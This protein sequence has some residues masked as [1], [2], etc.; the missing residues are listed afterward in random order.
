MVA[1]RPEPVILKNM[2]APTFSP[3]VLRLH[4]IEQSLIEADIRRY[5]QEALSTMSPVPSSDV[6]DQ[7]TRQSGKLFI[8]AATVARYINPEDKVVNSK[9]RLDVI[10]GISSS[11]ASLQEQE[12][13]KLYTTILSSAFDKDN[14]EEEELKVAALVLQTII[15]AIEPMTTS[16]MS[17]ILAVPREDVV[18]TLSRLQ[19]VLHVHE[20][21]SGLVSVL[22]MSFPDF[23]CS[24]ARSHEFYC[25]IV[26]HNTNLAH[27]CFDVMCQELHFNMCDL[28]SS[29]DFD[30]DEPD[31]ERKIQANMSATLLYAC[32]YWSDHLTHCDLTSSI[33]YRLVEFL[34]FRLL[35]WM[36][37]LNLSKSITIGSQ[38]LSNI[39]A[40][41]IRKAPEHTFKETEKELYDADLFVKSFSLRA[42][43]KSTP[44]IYISALPFCYKS[45]SV[46]Q[47]YWS[48]THGLMVVNGTSLTQH[49]NGPIGV[50]KLPWVYTVA[51]SPDGCT[52]AAGYGSCVDVRDVQSGEIV[53][54]SSLKDTELVSSMVFSP[55]NC[56]IAT[57]SENGNIRIWDI[58]T[59]N[60]TCGAG[61]S[62]GAWQDEPF[63]WTARTGARSCS[64]SA[65]SSLFA[66]FA[67]TERTLHSKLP[68]VGRLGPR[69]P[70]CFN[71]VCSC[72]AM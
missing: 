50:W 64:F 65:H 45:N 63:T 61:P 16:M 36:E 29:Y 30:E 26:E 69:P 1:S 41:F 67:L 66:H 72:W 59:A 53:F 68:S 14:F 51:F 39:L 24:K 44:H 62:H 60:S 42:C 12:L 5:L 9:T 70:S 56:K 8:Y 11:S 7:L 21:P 4:D 17:T 3:S 49:Q 37:V 31:L 25:N 71:V 20:G 34:K 46:Y 6:I 13:D 28:E 33:H 47:N 32:K 57:G 40:W 19:S 58:Q 52:F 23:L 27:S 48:K 35:F 2:Q 18:I 54:S 10:L 43:K 15:C 38:T 22:H 55:D